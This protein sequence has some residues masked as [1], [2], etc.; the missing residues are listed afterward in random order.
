MMKILRRWA[1]LL[2]PALV[3]VNA[4]H[5][6]AVTPVLPSYKTLDRVVA[7]QQGLATFYSALQK[8]GMDKILS[9][10][11]ILYTIFAPADS[12]FLA[13]GLTADSVSRIDA[14]QLSRL[15][16]YHIAVGNY[17]AG[18][19]KG[20]YLL[21][22]GMSDSLYAYIV[23]FM[24]ITINGAFLDSVDIP[25]RNGQVHVI[26]RVLNIPDRSLLQAINDDPDLSYL[27]AAFRILGWDEDFFYRVNGGTFLA[28]T[29]AAF[30]AKG[31]ADTARFPY[32]TEMLSQSL[33]SN[34]IY[35]QRFFPMQDLYG[36][37][38]TG[39]SLK[40]TGKKGAFRVELV[41]IAGSAGFIS[42]N[43]LCLNGVLHKI[44]KVLGK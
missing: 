11:G 44:D 18:R 42:Q 17:P 4:C 3:V 13:A 43:L 12:A 8:T 15:L 2:I 40:V 29:N 26:D 39:P 38:F 22:L 5:K 10:T 9:D 33:G 37:T 16:R 27:S 31:Y 23:F 19:F 20:G 1:Y 28:P 35:G 6:S 36:G 41:D 25:A 24:G 32:I 34:F 21:P 30:I 14:G 7:G